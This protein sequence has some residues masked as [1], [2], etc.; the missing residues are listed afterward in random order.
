MPLRSCKAVPSHSFYI[1][2]RLRN[3]VSDQS[4]LMAICYDILPKTAARLSTF[5]TKNKPFINILNS[6]TSYNHQ[7]AAECALAVRA[8]HCRASCS[9][10]E[11]SLQIPEY[12]LPSFIK[13]VRQER[14]RRR[15]LQQRRLPPA[16]GRVA[17]ALA[18]VQV[19]PLI[20]QVWRQILRHEEMAPRHN[21][22]RVMLRVPDAP[23]ASKAH[24]PEHK[25]L[26]QSGSGQQ[27]AALL[28]TDVDAVHV[29][30]LRVSLRRSATAEHD[31]PALHAPS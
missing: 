30:L 26:A 29:P 2:T 25:Q 21:A 23:R 6:T 9:Q 17:E 20:E 18:A 28:Q 10:L 7:A 8:A 13:H 4:K 24:Q 31:L 19:L 5:P 22:C 11:R 15:V 16:L 1:V 14:V 27:S 12:V 3:G